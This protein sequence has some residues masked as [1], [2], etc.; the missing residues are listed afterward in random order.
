MNWMKS[1]T[2]THTHTQMGMCD[3]VKILVVALFLVSVLFTRPSLTWNEVFP[4][5][6]FL[7]VVCRNLLLHLIVYVGRAL[8]YIQHGATPFSSLLWFWSLEIFAH[9]D[10]V[11][12]AETANS[13][14]VSS[15][16]LLF[17]FVMWRAYITVTRTSWRNTILMFTLH[18]FETWKFSCTKDMWFMLSL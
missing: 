3:M 15:A 8:W 11:I 18:G 12:V 9:S 14:K 1:R 13:C 2:N 5:N 7:L 4:R 17:V 16:Y 6:H 10:V